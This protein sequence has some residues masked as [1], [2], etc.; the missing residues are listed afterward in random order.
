MTEETGDFWRTKFAALQQKNMTATGRIRLTVQNIREEAAA[1]SEKFPSVL[2]S[3]SENGSGMEFEAEL[4]FELKIRLFVQ[5]QV[6]GSILQKTDAGFIKLGDAKFW[7]NPFPEL[8]DFVNH[9]KEY[10]SELEEWSTGRQ[11]FLKMQKLT[12]EMIKSILKKKLDGKGLV[13]FLEP[14]DSA[15]IL[16]TENAGNKQTHRLSMSCFVQ[17]INELKL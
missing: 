7:T 15:F 10:Q 6:K 11:K 8:E 5:N 3:V 1:F 2:V 4:S 9:F 17:E 12:G 13:W 14:T 16:T